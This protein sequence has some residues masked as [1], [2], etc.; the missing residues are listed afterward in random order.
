MIVKR[1]KFL[2]FFMAALA[3]LGAA[4]CAG[5]QNKVTARPES[6]EGKTTAASSSEQKPATAAAPYYYEFKHPDFVVNHVEIWHD[7]NGHGTIRFK[8]RTDAEAISDPLEIS[9]AALARIKGYYQAT[10]FLDSETSFLGKREYPSYGKTVL[11]LR[12]DGRERTVEFNYP[13]DPNALALMQEYRR[14]SEQAVFIFEIKLAVEMQPLEAPKLMNKLETLIRLNYIS[15]AKQL[16]PLIRQLSTD[17]RLPLIAR[18]HAVRLL[19]QMEKQ[20]P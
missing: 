10:G 15:D 20:Q 11:R 7:E 18:N 14:L 19:K 4:I 13:E 2:P 3:V 12:R 6:R 17:E 16:A 9:A 8:R 5:A 1:K